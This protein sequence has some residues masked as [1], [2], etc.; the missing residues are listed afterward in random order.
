[1]HGTH[2]NVAMRCCT[3]PIRS[4]V[5]ISQH[6]ESLLS[7]MLST[8]TIHCQEGALLYTARYQLHMHL[9]PRALIL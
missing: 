7:L 6:A 5:L 9:H 8:M 3:M 1:M 2:H 4:A